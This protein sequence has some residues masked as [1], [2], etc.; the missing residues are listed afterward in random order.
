VSVD[1][2]DR[3]SAGMEDDNGYYRGEMTGTGTGGKEGDIDQRD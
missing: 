2:R 1:V 3:V